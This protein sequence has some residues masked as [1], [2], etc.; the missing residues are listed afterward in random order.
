M[1]PVAR[2][3]ALQCELWPEFVGLA[4][5]GRM[6]FMSYRRGER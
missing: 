1:L 3:A 5:A 4:M 2:A 6:H